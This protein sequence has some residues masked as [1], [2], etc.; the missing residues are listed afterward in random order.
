MVSTSGKVG[1]VLRSNVL[2]IHYDNQAI[3]ISHLNNLL[4]AYQYLLDRVIYRQRPQSKLAIMIGVIAL[5]NNINRIYSFQLYR[6]YISI[7]QRSYLLKYTLTLV[8]T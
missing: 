2:S 7:I 6:K 8:L 4:L 3:F 5:C 1:E